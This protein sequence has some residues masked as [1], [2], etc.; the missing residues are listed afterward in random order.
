MLFDLLFLNEND[1]MDSIIIPEKF[2]IFNY[3]C[4]KFSVCTT[5]EN[6]FQKCV[7]KHNPLTYNEITKVLRK[8]NNSDRKERKKKE[9]ML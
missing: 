9:G 3:Q 7:D 5:Y 4:Q 2:L 6:I 1:K 8:Q